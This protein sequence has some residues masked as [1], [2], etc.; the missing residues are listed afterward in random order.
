MI[1]TNWP[2]CILDANDASN[3]GPGT[4]PADDD[5]A[6]HVHARSTPATDVHAAR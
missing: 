2:P 6:T 5:A 4:R 3:D 1:R